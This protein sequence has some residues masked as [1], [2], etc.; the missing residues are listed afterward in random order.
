[1]QNKSMEETFLLD[2][3]YVLYVFMYFHFTN[4]MLGNIIQMD[5][6]WSHPLAG[7][8]RFFS[9]IVMGIQFTRMEN[10][11]GQLQAETR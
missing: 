5:I 7:F 3:S 8:F 2:G 4:T 10:Q 6:N 11:H 9:G 1:M